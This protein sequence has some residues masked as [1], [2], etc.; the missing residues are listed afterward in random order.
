MKIY[1]IN[2]PNLNLLGRREPEIYGNVTFEDFFKEL[3]V[4]FPSIEL[5]YFQSNIEGELVDKL[6]EIGFSYDGIILNAGA[7]THTSIAIGDCIKAIAAPVIEVHI[8][9]TFSREE[10][11]H[12]SYISPNAKGVILGF[13]LQSYQLALQSFISINANDFV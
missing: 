7:Y 8:S 10:F 4:L 9:N 12:Q 2:G 6:Q 1:I 3:K 5:S 11:R 13:G